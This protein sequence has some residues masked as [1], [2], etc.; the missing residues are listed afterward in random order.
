[1]TL[2]DI[3]KSFTT[4]QSQL[5]KHSRQA[6]K[7]ASPRRHRASPPR[8]DR[9][10]HAAHFADTDEIAYTTVMEDDDAML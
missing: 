4:I 1:V 6:A 10:A 8:L 5:D 2:A 3:Q 9:A 7:T